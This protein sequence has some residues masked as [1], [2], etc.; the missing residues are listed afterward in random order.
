MNNEIKI[1]RFYNLKYIIRS[2]T[3]IT[4]FVAIVLGICVGILSNR[5]KPD[6]LEIIE[7]TV[8]TVYYDEDEED[9]VIEIR[10]FETAFKVS[11]NY[12]E[13]TNLCEVLKVGENIKIHYYKSTTKFDRAILV[14]LETEN[15]FSIDLSDNFLMDLKFVFYFMLGLIGIGLVLLI[16]TIILFKKKVYKTYN[17]FAYSAKHSLVPFIYYDD[18]KPLERTKKQNKALIIYI[19]SIILLGIFI[20]VTGMAFEEYP[21]ILIPIDVSLFII[22]TIYLF[23]SRGLR[24]YKENEVKIFVKKYLYFLE[25]EKEDYIGLTFDKEE[26][27][28][29]DYDYDYDFETDETIETIK[30]LPYEKMNFYVCCYFQK[31]FH[32]AYIFI[33]SDEIIYDHPFM[34]SLNPKSYQEIKENN[35][36]IEGLDYLINNLEKEIITNNQNKIKFKSYQGEC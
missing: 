30:T 15:N 20:A 10:D 18:L 13:V 1:E 23:S 25:N 26:F 33:C 2:I 9:Y 34:I 5:H 29:L 17:Y 31:K 28:Y 22:I 11:K 3:I 8:K 27:I 32:S 19:I 14:K 24:V 35:I 12:K 16:I 6:N 21:H 4:F 36:Y 7:S